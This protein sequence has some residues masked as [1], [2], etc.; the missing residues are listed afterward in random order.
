MSEPL[1]RIEGLKYAYGKHFVLDIPDLV[2]QPGESLGLVGPNGSGKSTLL[3]LLAFVDSPAEGKIFFEGV[4]VDAESHEIKLYVTMLLQVAYLLKRTVFEN[5]AYG[6]RIRGDMADAGKRVS[7]AMTWVGLSPEKF[8]HRLWHQLSGGEAQR[9]ALAARLVLRPKVLVLDEPTASVDLQSSHLIKDAIDRCRRMFNTSLIIVSHDHFWLDTVSDTI[10]RMDEGRL[11]EYVGG[12][13]IHGP[14][15]EGKDGLF[16]K[17]LQDGQA[18]V[19]TRVQHPEASVVLDPSSITIAAEPLREASAQNILKCRITRMS[20]EPSTGSI[21][22][23]VA[24]AQVRLNVRITRPSAVK[25][26]LVPG[27]EV[28]V[29]FKATSLQWD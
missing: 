24:V 16:R 29:V 4:P 9:V 17:R 2:I 12:N 28:W 22:V 13:V 5:V 15:E 21:L 27:K 20:D 10:R 3:R 8:A 6:L 19:S 7:E 18:I 1:Y 25:L 23:E 26:Q 11:K 14:W